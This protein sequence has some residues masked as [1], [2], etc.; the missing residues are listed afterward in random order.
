MLFYI[1]YIIYIIYKQCIYI[2][3]IIN[4]IYYFI[5]NAYIK[6]YITYKY[7]LYMDMYKNIYL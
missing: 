1:I 2:V 3:Y 5:L 6:E 4:K 7:I